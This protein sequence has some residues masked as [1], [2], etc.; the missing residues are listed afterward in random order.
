MT[1]PLLLTM[2]TDLL[3]DLLG[4]AAAAGVAV[5]VAVEPAGC[6]PQWT[7]APLVLL[8][9]DLAA[10]LP[11][12]RLRPRPGV[13]LVARGSPTEELRE[14]AAVVGAEAIVLPEGEPAILDRLADTAE[15][16]ARGR[17]IG[18]LGGRGGAGASVLAAGLALTAVAPAWLIDLDPLGG[19]ADAGLG[20]ELSAGARWADLGLLAGRLSPTAL[21]DAVPEVCGVSVLA[22][23]H[24]VEELKPDT[25]RTVIRAASRGGGTVVLDLPRHRTAARDQALVLVDEVLVVVPAEIR[26]VLAA[27]RVVQGLPT[28]PRV[29]VR[30]VPGALPASEVVRGLGLPFAGQLS[31]EV[32]VRAAA[33]VGDPAGLVRGTELAELCRTLLD[34]SDVLAVAA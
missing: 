12:A 2:D 15:P 11:S 21:R 1:R 22:T 28:T 17:V 27:R 16:A 18:V 24:P 33:Q 10:A 30:T 13:L 19:G 8:G 25:V 32:T 20:A 29:V 5:D 9:A 3:D 23:A 14:T 26:A 34:R 6:R 7:N 4:M 31:D